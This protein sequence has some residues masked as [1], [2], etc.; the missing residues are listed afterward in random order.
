M[1]LAW[2]NDKAAFSLQRMQWELPSR[3][4]ELV[5]LYKIQWGGCLLKPDLRDIHDICNTLHT[6]SIEWN[7]RI[8]ASLSR[9]PTL[10]YVAR[11]PVS[12]RSMR[13]GK[14]SLHFEQFKQL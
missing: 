4:R 2:G 11:I 8:I 13:V 6:Q 7:D 1:L 9:F 5:S 12:V 3:L 10:F 14:A